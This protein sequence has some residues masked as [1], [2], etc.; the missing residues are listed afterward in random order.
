MGTKDKRID[1]Y[2]AKSADYAKPILAHLRKLINKTC[3]EVTETIKWGMPAFEYKG[4]FI[5]FA[6]FKKHAVLSFW[7]AALM[8]DAKFLTG[9]GT[10]ESMGNLG[11]IESIEDLPKDKILINWI[12]DAMKLNESGI[13]FNPSSKPKHKKNEYSMHPDF[14][15]A[16]S[17]NKAAKKTFESFSPS[18]KKEYLEWIGEVKTDETREKRINTAIDW[19]AEGKSRNWKY[20]KKLILMK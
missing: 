2:I 3:P 15:K 6:A 11:R 13:K 1:A 14:E 9:K 17:K 5:F 8:S 18:H 20:Q 10:K 4:P 12:K 16:L 7:K 19:I